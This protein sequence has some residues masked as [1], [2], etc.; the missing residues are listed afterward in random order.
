M[1]LQFNKKYAILF[2]AIFMV[3]ILIAKFL[4]QGFIR[5]TFG[6]FLVVILMYCFVKS[7]VSVKPKYIAIGVLIFTYAIEFLQFFK[8]LD[9][10]NLQ[11]NKTANVVLGSTF[12][13]SDLISYTLGIITVLIVEY[14][15]RPSDFK[16]LL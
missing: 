11:G 9:F 16:T 7:L 3:E 12:Q 15:I 5:S 2:V 13:I 8:L 14:K 10:L 1:K 6:D 4:I